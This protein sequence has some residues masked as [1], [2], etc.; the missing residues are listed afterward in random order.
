[1]AVETT[2]VVETT[3]ELAVVE[4]QAVV[5]PTGNDELYL[6]LAEDARD[7]MIGNW[8]WPLAS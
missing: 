8:Q 2:S 1:M 6:P 7:P 5:P 4:W 3:V